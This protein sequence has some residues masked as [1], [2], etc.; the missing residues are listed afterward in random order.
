VITQQASTIV[1]INYTFQPT[2]RG[3]QVRIVTHEP[4]ALKAIHEFLAIQ[5]R[6]HR[7]GDSL[8][9]KSKS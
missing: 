8:Q 6:D 2:D 4:D 5:V 7:T 9:V 1:A 3:G